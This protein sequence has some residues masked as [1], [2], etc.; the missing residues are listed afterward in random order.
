MCQQ[1]SG[2]NAVFYYS[3]TFFEVSGEVS[4]DF[5]KPDV[6]KLHRMQKINKNLSDPGTL[7]S[8]GVNALAMG[9]AVQLM[10]R[11]G[12]RKL[13]LSGSFGM[14]VSALLIVIAMSIRVRFLDKL[15]SSACCT[16]INDLK[17]AESGI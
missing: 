2:A 8:S 14:A 17:F 7:L 6:S 12:R 1:I 16:C 10:E 11:A 5:Y 15:S 4:K 13:L 9:V 3:T